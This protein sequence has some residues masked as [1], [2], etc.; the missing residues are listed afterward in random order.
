MK[1]NKKLINI[2]NIMFI[3]VLCLFAVSLVEKKFQNDTFFTIA[4]GQRTV[5]HGIEEYDQL[6]WHDNLRFIHLRWLFDVVIYGL[7]NTF[8]YAGIYIFVLILAVIQGLMYYA[9]MNSFTKNKIFSFFSSI[10]LISWN[11]YSVAARGQIMSFTLFLIEF[12]ALNK[13]INEKKKIFIPVLLTIPLL[14]VNFHASVLPV[15]FVFYLPYIAEYIVSK[16]KIINS[17]ESKILVNKIDNK[18]FITLVIIMVLSLFIG[19]ISP[20]GI[21]AYKYMFNVMGGVSTDFIA[22]L[23]PVKFADNPAYVF[24]IVLFVVMIGFT[25]IKVRLTDLLYIVG[26]L[27]LSLPTNRCIF[28][29]YMFAGSCILR[30]TFEFIKDSKFKINVYENKILI[31]L[32]IL[33]LVLII[34]SSI[35]GIYNKCEEPYV[36]YEKLPENATNY[37]LNN[38]NQDNMRIFNHFD[39][40]SF[41]EYKGIKVFLDSR[42]EMYTEEFNEG[43]TILEDWYLTDVGKK[44]YKELMEK[45]DITHAILYNDEL[46]A[47]YM[48]DDENWNCMYKDD[49]FCIYEK[50][51][52]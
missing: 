39:F 41:M 5:E 37:I 10:A 52:K 28:F 9:I 31:A 4:L 27:V 40:G 24:L 32:L 30:I 45:Y 50:V 3:V 17:E 29:F 12:Y 43:V 19:L 48:A 42:S 25:K 18:T 15:Y 21:D 8:G 46:T 13:L 35:K 23:Q 7:N 51:N 6:V 38:I 26:F 44:S 16:L 2:I 33:V 49:T 1:S 36:D 22:E 20:I 14:V 34:V 11:G 47:L